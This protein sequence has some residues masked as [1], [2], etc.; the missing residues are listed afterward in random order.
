LPPAQP[1]LVRQGQGRGQGQGQE[2]LAVW[3]PEL[4]ELETGERV[5]ETGERVLW[6]LA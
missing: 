5:L 1:V 4:R 2:P 6:E 3:V